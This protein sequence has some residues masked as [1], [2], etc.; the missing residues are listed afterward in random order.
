MNPYSILNIATA[1]TDEEI[2]AAYRLLTQKYGSDEY[3]N[4]ELSEIAKQKQAELDNAFDMIMSERRVQYIHID[5]DYKPASK[6]NYN[7]GQTGDYEY[8]R[9]CLNRGDSITAEQQL[10]AVETSKRNAE[11]NYL[12][13]V[14]CQ[15]KGWLNDSARYFSVAHEMDPQNI[16]YASSYDK[17]V[18]Y[19]QSGPA[20]NPYSQ[21]RASGADDTLCTFLQ[22]ACC[23]SLCRGCC[24]R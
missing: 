9:D 7:G 22:C 17:F 3:A 2:R 8:I 14:L 10:L 13:G 6:N 21:S 20:Y 12:M 5:S 23:L 15:N 4:S 1:A 11:W 18:R 16:E 24:C 19:R